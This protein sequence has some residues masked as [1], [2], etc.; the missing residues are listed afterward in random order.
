MN[1][2]PRSSASLQRQESRPVPDDALPAAPPPVPEAKGPPDQAGVTDGTVVNPHAIDHHAVVDFNGGTF[3][4]GETGVR[5]M[6]MLSRSAGGG[7]PRPG[8]SATEDALDNARLV[9]RE[10]DREA[11]FRA[12]MQR[13]DAPVS[14]DA[15]PREE[16]RPPTG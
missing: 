6:R 2:Q 12:R 8:S 10:L 13:G 14:P 16:S 3:F 15:S 11:A 4:M 9:L 5:A 1:I 7:G